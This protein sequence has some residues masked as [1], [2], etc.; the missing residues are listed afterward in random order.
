[1]GTR[2]AWTTALSWRSAR[3]RSA[4]A[5]HSGP[6]RWTERRI[7]PLVSAFER[8][9]QPSG[10]GSSTARSTGG[11]ASIKER[12]ARILERGTGHDDRAAEV[13][14]QPGPGHGLEN[15]QE[16]LGRILER[17]ARRTQERMREELS[18]VLGRA[19]PVAR[20]ELAHHKQQDGTTHPHRPR[21]R[22]HRVQRHR[23]E[24]DHGW[25]P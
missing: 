25:A 21:G 12:L 7:G 3:R 20:D 24:D 18:A 23:H 8:R 15:A 6:R 10:G 22:G 17:E 2:H 11:L 14:R 16:R 5:M 1:M 4:T 9:E 13:R 19:R